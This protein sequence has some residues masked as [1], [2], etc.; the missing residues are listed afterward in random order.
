MSHSLKPDRAGRVD[1][2]IMRAMLLTAP[3]PAAF[4]VLAI[5]LIGR[6]GRL[7]EGVEQIVGQRLDQQPRNE[8]VTAQHAAHVA[9]ARARAHADVLV[10]DAAKDL[11]PLEYALDEQ[12]EAPFSGSM[13]S[14]DFLAMSMHGVDGNA[15]FRFV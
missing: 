1:A 4:Q 6:N 11:R 5:D 9:D 3:A 8:K 14:T 13:M 12:G 7:Q 10:D 2:T 15:D